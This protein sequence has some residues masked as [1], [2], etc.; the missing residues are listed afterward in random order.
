[1]LRHGGMDRLFSRGAGPV[2]VGHVSGTFRFGHVRQLDEVASRFLVGPDTL[3]RHR[4][5]RPL[6]LRVRQAGHGLRVHLG[7]P[8]S[9]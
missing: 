7:Q 3:R 8:A 2:D 6:H 5:H 9:A 4:R 1:M